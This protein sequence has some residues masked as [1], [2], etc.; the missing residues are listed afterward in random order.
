MQQISEE[1]CRSK[2]RKAVEYIQMTT[3]IVEKVEC[4]VG[5]EDRSRFPF[6]LL[7]NYNVGTEEL[8]LMQLHICITITK[9]LALQC[10]ADK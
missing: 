8:F 5:W 9:N 1:L 3:Y 10:N 6:S 7:L 2:M 4:R